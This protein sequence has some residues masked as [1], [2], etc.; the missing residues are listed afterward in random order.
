MD[1]IAKGLRAEKVHYCLV[2]KSWKA[3]PD[4]RERREMAK[5][6]AAYLEG[7]PTQM[8]VNLSA[9][10]AG[11]PKLADVLRASPNGRRAVEAFLARMET[12]GGSPA[13][14]ASSA[15]VEV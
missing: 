1:V 15:A 11:Q 9:G 6:A 12:P 3:E 13:S 7:L 4:Y 8:V 14:P 10:G 2:S 5:L